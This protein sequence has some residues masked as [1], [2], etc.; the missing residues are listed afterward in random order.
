M[1]PKPSEA[2]RW[3]ECNGA[4]ALGEQFPERSVS[5][6]RAEG[7]ASHWAG[8]LGLK[9]QAVPV[10]TLAPN[11]VVL[12]EEMLEGA[13]MWVDDVLSIAAERNLVS[14]LQ[15]ESPIPLD[16]V[17]PGMEARADVWLF[18]Q[19]AGVLTVW[20]YKF[21][22]TLVE[23][24]D[25]WQLAIETCGILDLLGVDGAAEQH[26]T[27]DLRV[28]QPRAWHRDGRVRS[29]RVKA[30]DLRGHFNR[31][32]H[33][34][35]AAAQPGALL[36]A[37]PHCLNCRAASGC[38]TLR[39]SVMAIADWAESARP[40]QLPP[41]ALGAE[42]VLLEM[43]SKLVKSRHTAVEAEVEAALREGSA[44][45]GWALEPAYGRQRW[46]HPAEDVATL[47]DLLGV[48]LRKPLDVV[49]PSQAKKAGVDAA[50]IQSYSEH[51]SA[52]FKLARDVNLTRR[53]RAAFGVKSNG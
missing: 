25:N 9:G 47:G 33:A 32:A 34:A 30:A 12:T 7:I 22:R 11:G 49:T 26:L 36:K 13:E 27:V 50:V 1:I 18:D 46:T 29:W 45:D 24:V 2:F 17:L 48:N 5:P 37:G 40:E 42:L 21:G 4:P 35:H 53:A 23:A 10:G 28:V 8:A 14:H 16:R 20:D 51:P 19:A 44:V 31:L 38:P 6:S 3:V 52:G 39:R 43:L 41:D 15:I